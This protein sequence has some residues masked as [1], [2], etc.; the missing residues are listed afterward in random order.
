VVDVLKGCRVLPA[1]VWGVP[2]NLFFFSL[3]AAGG[4]KKKEKGF[5]GDTPNPGRRLAAL[6]TPA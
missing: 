2:R 3:A 1:G 5:F 6:C 4:E